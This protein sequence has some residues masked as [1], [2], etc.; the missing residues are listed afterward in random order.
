MNCLRTLQK[1]Q[2]L[3]E[4][5]SKN[6]NG[7]P[8]TKMEN[9][10]GDPKTKT[11]NQK[12]KRR[13]KNQKR[14]TKNQNRDPK[15]KNGEPKTKTENQKTKSENQKPKW[16]CLSKFCHFA[17]WEKHWDFILAASQSWAKQIG[18]NKFD[19]ACTVVEIN[20]YILSLFK[21]WCSALRSGWGH[22]MLNKISQCT[23]LRARFLAWL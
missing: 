9:Q 14:R 23:K 22:H 5:L 13:S 8:K 12:P 16:R 7:E 17:T 15:T 18:A 11:E 19:V 21:A 4:T 1:W 20:L 3:E 10:N 2:K 6:Q